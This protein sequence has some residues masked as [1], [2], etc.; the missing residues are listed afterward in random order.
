[1][2][3]RPATSIEALAKLR[4][5]F[6]ADGSVTAGNACPLN[7]GA[8]LVLVMSRGMAKGSLFH[9]QHRRR[10]RSRVA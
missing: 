6:L 4:P 2:R 5:V 8:C 3:P 7:D 9:R 1:M 10:R